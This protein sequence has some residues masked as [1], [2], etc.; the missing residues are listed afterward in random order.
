MIVQG[1]DNLGGVLEVLNWDVGWEELIPNEE[2]EVQEMPDLD[3]LAVS[4]VLSVL[5]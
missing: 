2:D 4:G 1:K 3:F 5:V